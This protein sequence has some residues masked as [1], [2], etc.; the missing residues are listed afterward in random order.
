MHDLLAVPEK[1][2]STESKDQF[3]KRSGITCVQTTDFSKVLKLYISSTATPN[4]CSILEYN[5]SPHRLHEPSD[6]CY[7]A[8]HGLQS[9]VVHCSKRVQQ[10]RLQKILFKMVYRLWRTILHDRRIRKKTS[11]QRS[12][13]ASTFFKSPLYPIHAEVSCFCAAE[14]DSH[15]LRHKALS[16]F[17][18]VVVEYQDLRRLTGEVE[19]VVKLSQC[20][21]RVVPH[22]HWFGFRPKVFGKL[23]NQPTFNEHICIIELL[24]RATDQIWAS[25]IVPIAPVDFT[26]YWKSSHLT[27]AANL[28]SVHMT[29]MEHGIHH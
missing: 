15:K 21:N 9:M 4:L 2:K 10:C 29:W 19:M 24:E 11:C 1:T 28:V 14:D 5:A 12:K 18:F 27:L 23:S 17:Q 13:H 20:N 6:A 16:C 7:A 25:H 26:P 8:Y 3:V 22:S